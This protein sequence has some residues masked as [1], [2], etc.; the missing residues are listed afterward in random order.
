MRVEKWYLDCVN[1]DGAGMIGYA[2]RLSWG[3]L[4]VRVAET[5]FWRTGEPAIT[6]R[7]VLGGRLPVAT[8][9]DIIWH[10]PVL[11]APGRWR[12]LNR[13]I[14]ATLLHRETAGWIEWTCLCPAAQATVNVGGHLL[15][16]LGYAERIVLTLPPARLP[17]RELRWGRFI[18]G[19]HSCVWIRW[20]GRVERNWCFHN[21]R[22]VEALIRDRYELSWTG[23]RLHLDFGT[24]LRS[25]RIGDTALPDSRLLR[26][27]LPAT[28]LDLEETK[29]C[30]RGVLTDADG[31]EHPGWAV[32][33][34]VIFPENQ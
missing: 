13:G 34:V 2:A 9:G 11:G 29:W 21:G 1:S 31:K 6:Q 10:S 28:V 27:L 22:P 3:P 17:I 25:G 30:S 7:T 18:A 33:E 4:A 16:G 32:H 26:R 20:Q 14:P 19:G 8:N 24:T 15:E 12:Q 23:H 5:M